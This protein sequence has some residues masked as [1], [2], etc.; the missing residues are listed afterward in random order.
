MGIRLH[1]HVLLLCWWPVHA[2]T[3]QAGPMHERPHQRLSSPCAPR[4]VPTP[5]HAACQSECPQETRT[6]CGVDGKNYANACKAACKGVRVASQGRCPQKKAQQQAAGAVKP[7][8]AASKPKNAQAYDKPLKP[9]PAQ[10][11]KTLVVV[12]KPLTIK[13]PCAATADLN[14]VCGADGITYGEML[15]PYIEPYT[16]PAGLSLRTASAGLIEL[17]NFTPLGVH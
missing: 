12:P 15:E 10:P 8:A 5:T 11:H 6:V 2:V 9:V 3:L 16:A 4:P 13:P 1:V 14:P 7:Q 17:E